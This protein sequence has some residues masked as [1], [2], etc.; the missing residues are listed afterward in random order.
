MPQL[1]PVLV[2]RDPVA[3]QAGASSS[4]REQERSADSAALHLAMR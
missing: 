2:A 1:G 3:V 4:E